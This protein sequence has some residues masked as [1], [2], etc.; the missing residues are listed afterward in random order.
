M[1]SPG[2]LGFVTLADTVRVVQLVKHEACLIMDLL[3]GFLVGD[4]GMLTESCLSPFK[5]PSNAIKSDGRDAGDKN[6]HIRWF[7]VKTHLADSD[8][9]AR[10]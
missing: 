6:V 4:V 2:R 5:Q 1:G 10:L 7:L 9:S 8:S 3:L